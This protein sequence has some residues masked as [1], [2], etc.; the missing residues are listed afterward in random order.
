MENDR[1][2]RVMW[3]LNHTSA[4]KFEIPMLKRMGVQEFF[5]PKSFPGDPSFRSASVDWSEDSHLSIPAEDLQVLNN[6]DWYAGAT[7]AAWQIADRHFDIVFSTLTNAALIENAA[8]YFKGVIVWRVFGFIQARTQ[9]KFLRTLSPNGRARHAIEALS[10]RFFFGEAYS[11]LA[12]QEPDFL[13]GRRIFLPLGL[14]DTTNAGGWEGKDARILFVRPDI[15]LNPYYKKVYADFKRNF[16]DLPYLIG[17]AQPV[18][19]DDPNVLGFVPREQ[20]EQNMK[21][22]RVMFYHSDEPCHLHYHPLEA[23][24]S[25]M[26]LIFMGGGLLDRMG[27]LGLP[28]RCTS[29]REAKEKLRR[30]LAGEASLM[31]QVL[32]S[33]PVLLRNMTVEHCLAGWSLGF[34]LLKRAAIAAREATTARPLAAQ[35]RKRVAVILPVAYRGGTLRAAKS[36]AQALVIGSAQQ[37]EKADI[38]LL[39]V[40]DPITYSEEDF[41]D[42]DAAVHRRPFKWKELDASEARR[43]M[44]YAGYKDWE[45]TSSTYLVPDDGI[46]QLQD[47]DVWCLVS[48]RLEHPLLPIKPV[49]MVVYDYLQRYWVQLQQNADISFIQ[50]ARAADRVLVTTDFTRQDAVQYAGLDPRK[51]RQVPMLAS[52]FERLDLAPRREGKSL[53]FVWSTNLGL[54]KNHGRAAQALKIYYEELGGTLN[55]VLTG[56]NVAEILNSTAPHLSDFSEILSQSKKTRRAVKIKGEL[57][58]GDYQ[59]KLVH[60]QFLWHPTLLDNGTFSA[61][62]AACLGTPTL[63][64]DYPAMR[65][66]DQ[67]F[68]LA[69]AW[70]DGTSARKMAEALKWMEMNAEAQRQQLPSM[71]TLNEQSVDKLAGSYW[72]EIQPC[73]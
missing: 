62:E 57:S 72:R 4:R 66:M 20:H 38:A 40:D 36:L 12:D 9:Y 51:V 58:D 65:E 49:V 27:G 6:T 59:H 43:A 5:L 35:R 3:L 50:A 14:P 55:C 7:P 45:P 17:G 10:K 16:G 53:Y 52:L 44:R 26:P 1:P 22:L 61:V 13:R 56:V 30:L 46:Q 28:G 68:G 11:H 47:C 31:A 60:A 71:E 34:T 19:V 18:A 32:N 37:G 54:H 23:V 73:L 24:R 69:M 39:H 8:R 21:Q 25:G 64:S 70:M 15:A 29:V 33:Q 67:Q 41:W 48:D 42:L 2:L 63:S